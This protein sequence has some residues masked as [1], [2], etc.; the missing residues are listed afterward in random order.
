MC[1]RASGHNWATTQP[2][3]SECHSSGTNLGFK[4]FKNDHPQELN[5][6]G[7]G[8]YNSEQRWVN[9][10]ANK[11]SPSQPVLT[12][13]PSKSYEGIPRAVLTRIQVSNVPF[14]WVGGE[15]SAK[16][17]LTKG[18]LVNH[19]HGAL[20]P[21]IRF[22]QEIKKKLRGLRNTCYLFISTGLVEGKNRIKDDG[23]FNSEERRAV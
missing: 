2:L 23:L 21:G 20:N 10:E 4:W 18:E 13:A 15:K 16:C 14:S 5:S 8:N 7:V 6:S 12:P 9:H 19:L 17:C 1:N 22:V 3:N 11:A